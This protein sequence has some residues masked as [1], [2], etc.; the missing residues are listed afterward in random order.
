MSNNLSI[1]FLFL[2]LY[3]AISKGDTYAMEVGSTVIKV[4]ESLAWKFPYRLVWQSKV[5]PVPWL[6]P[7]TDDA[8]RGMAYVRD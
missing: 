3:Q 1:S 7:H 6:S 5:G 4:M 2:F 8:L